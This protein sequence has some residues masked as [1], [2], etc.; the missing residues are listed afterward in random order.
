MSPKLPYLALLIPQPTYTLVDSQPAPLTHRQEFCIYYYL[1]ITRKDKVDRSEMIKWLGYKETQNGS[2]NTT[3]SQL[4]KWFEKYDIFP[5]N[6]NERGSVQFNPESINSDFYTFED[7]LKKI[8]SLTE[9]H[10]NITDMNLLNETL[11]LYQAPLLGNLPNG[12]RNKVP[13][14]AQWAEERRD[15]LRQ[16][17]RKVLKRYCWA[18]I[19]Q[20]VSA[21]HSTLLQ[22]LQRIDRCD[23]DALTYELV[24]YWLYLALMVENHPAFESGLMRLTKMPKPNTPPKLTPKEWR[25]ALDTRTRPPLENLIGGG[26]LAVESALVELIQ[27]IAN[28]AIKGAKS[29]ILM[30]GQPGIG[31]T[32]L[33]Q[34]IVGLLNGRG[35]FKVA[36]LGPTTNKGRGLSM[37]FNEALAKFGLSS[38]SNST[39]PESSLDRRKRGQAEFS[40]GHYVLVYDRPLADEKEL[41]RLHNLFTGVQVVVM[42]DN[43]GWIDSTLKASE[44][45]VYRPIEPQDADAV[46]A[47]INR[48]RAT[49]N[50]PPVT[51][52][53]WGGIQE[54]TGGLMLLLQIVNAILSARFQQAPDKCLGRLSRSTRVKG[55]TTPYETFAHWLL[56]EAGDPL[57][58][59]ERELLYA[60]ALFDRDRV[61]SAEDLLAVTNSPAVCEETLQQ[62]VSYHLLRP[63]EV[64]DQVVGYHLHP[65]LHDAINQVWPLSSPLYPQMVENYHALILQKVLNATGHADLDLIKRDMVKVLKVIFEDTPTETDVERLIS[66]YSYFDQS[67][68]YP[69]ALPLY[70][71]ALEKGSYA[72]DLRAQLLCA[73]GK[74]LLKHGEPKKAKECFERAMDIIEPLNEQLL[75]LELYRDFGRTMMLT[76]LYDEAERYFVEAL[77]QP[78]NTSDKPMSP[79]YAARCWLTI[80]HI[81]ANRSVV[82]QCT[83][84]YTEAVEMLTPII[85]RTDFHLLEGLLD[86]DVKLLEQFIV[87]LLGL[88]EME[89][90][91]GHTDT[92]ID[93]LKQAENLAEKWP[94]RRARS[95]LNLGVVA[96]LSGDTAEAKRCFEEAQTLASASQH[97]EL[98]ALLRFNTGMVGLV[99]GVFGDDVI[100]ELDMAYESVR[101]YHFNHI[102]PHL[103]I[104]YAIT[105]LKFRNIKTSKQYLDK[106]LKEVNFPADLHKPQVI[107]RALFGLALLLYPSVAV[108]LKESPQE[109]ADALTEKSSDFSRQLHAFAAKEH[110]DVGQEFKNAQSYYAQFKVPGADAEHLVEALTLIA[111]SLTPNQSPDRNEP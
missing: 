63:V 74:L 42:A 13:T 39:K 56:A 91:D 99:E 79:L 108:F 17:L 111:Q 51:G 54:A 45:Y 81:Y 31:K 73:K 5:P 32:T 87:N 64:G 109:L 44:R 90:P 96:Y 22:E 76:G 102:L 85:E 28:G 77:K 43:E 88:I 105:T 55:L 11:A 104:G 103:Y 97:W 101:E 33:A 66:L 29:T 89:R 34:K 23:P 37:V 100:Q 59:A 40:L 2:F 65:A 38:A 58:A 68:M 47:F 14:L 61:V 20:P 62:L 52:V 9:Q 4:R 18:F 98:E 86:D 49:I 19:R 41:A 8:L 30:V 94:E 67:G 53:N 75:R 83:G 93:Y 46:E 78:K 16:T 57:R 80:L 70:E 92:A 60:A 36:Y 82:R 27:D 72:P 21:A 48:G 107:G 7:N 26:G 50:R 10:V 95:L 15:D 35:E 106:V 3:L 110:V 12:W 1:I 6:H 25:V 84:K 71:A 24:E 69:E